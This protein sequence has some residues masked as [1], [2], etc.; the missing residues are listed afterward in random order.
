MQR[1]QDG[2]IILGGGRYTVPEHDYVG[3]TDDSVKLD[4][5][6]EHFRRACKQ[7]FDGWGEEA[8]GEG[9]LCDWTGIMGDTADGVLSVIYF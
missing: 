9:L 3:Q 1:P 2:V 8:A 4:T 7:Y 6:T 5:A